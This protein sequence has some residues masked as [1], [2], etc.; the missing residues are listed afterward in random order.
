MNKKSF[1]SLDIIFNSVLVVQ[2]IIGFIFYYLVNNASFNPVLAEFKF[3]PLVVLAVNTIAILSAKFLFAKRSK[4]D[5]KL[6]IDEKVRLYKSHSIVIIALIDAVN[7]FN[8][9]IFL[10]NG[11]TI[12]LIVAVL[13]L[14]LYFVYR[15]SAEKFAKDSLTQEEE[16]LFLTE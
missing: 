1:R 9:V 16:N 12:Y 3:L 10:L 7:I 8:L 11:S 15:P 2:L 13:I 14:I 4:I 5:K 6:S